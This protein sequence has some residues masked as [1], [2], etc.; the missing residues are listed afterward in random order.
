MRRV[1]L[2]LSVL[3]ACGSGP[4]DTA[5]VAADDA[6]LGPRGD[7]NPVDGE[8]CMLPFPSSFFLEE[9]ETPS[10][11]R[12]AFGP[13]SLPIN[14]DDVRLNPVRWNEKDG[15]PILGSA[16]AMLPGA[17]ADGAASAW[18][19]GLSVDDASPTLIINA[20]TGERVPHF[21]ERDPV[22]TDPERAVM[23]L[24]PIA[25]MDHDARYVVAIRGLKDGTGAV[26]PPPEGFR[27]LRDGLATT[28]P[29]LERQ[30][31]HYQDDILPVLTAEGW[32]VDALQLAWDF[33]TVSA[34]G[35]LGPV[36]H[37]RDEALE[38]VGDDGPAY[39]IDDVSTADCAAGARIGRSIVGHM[40][41]P[42][43]L[44]QDAPGPP[45][46]LHMG[47]DGL[48]EPVGEVDVPFLVRVPCSLIDDPRPGLPLA[49]GHGLFGQYEHVA[50]GPVDRL[51]AENG[52]VSFG[53]SWKGM[54]EE[55][56]MA[57]SLVMAQDQS[58]FAMLTDRLQQ[59]QIEWVLMSHLM[60]SGLAS[61]P[62]LM[63]DDVSLIDPSEVLFY[64]LSQGAVL[65]G[66]QVAMNPYIHRAAFS[67]PG[68]PF[69]MLLT[70]AANFMPFFL[71]LN[72]EFDDSADI[73]AIL[74]LTQMLWDPGESGGWA[75]YITEQPIDAT[76]PSDKSVLMQDAIGD[77]SVS[78]LGAQVMA[79]STGAK[80]VAPA[81]RP[82]FG[83]EEA[84]APFV[85]SA[86]L[87]MDFGYEEPDPSTLVVGEIG[88][89]NEPFSSTK[90][91]Q[92][93]AQFLLNGEVIQPC[94]GACDPD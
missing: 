2:V 41:V 15:F 1:L 50:N 48:P 44:E 39:V 55:D 36:L 54:A 7:C 24:K 58:D 60:L 71:I 59:G 76:V 49:F 27:V 51:A 84:E 12:V 8:H 70:R 11:L 43:Y 92:Q 57:V 64:G 33:E 88:P 10:G 65:G 72:A 20:E 66:A 68:M 82:V 13:E 29:D 81:V 62:A 89:H 31:A 37:M 52:W 79:R 19:P 77:R 28:D 22:A 61:D 63:V 80:L 46:V 38:L 9:A 67:V 47:D 3:T 14:L 93:I 17:T 26:V 34:E 90:G 23:L 5:P 25:P 83:V 42:Q 86:L 21:V 18:D 78:T 85:G 91:R 16:M 53:I 73:S 4:A 74:A 40:Q 69:S 35:S 6:A 94:D 30:R 75:H 56:V 32:D 45:S 87:E